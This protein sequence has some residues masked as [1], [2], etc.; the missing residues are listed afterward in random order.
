MGDGAEYERIVIY[1]DDIDPRKRGRL[2]EFLRGLGICFEYE[3]FA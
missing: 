3:Q 2:F 1:P